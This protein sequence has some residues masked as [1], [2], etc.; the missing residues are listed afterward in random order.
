MT[1]GRT[2][3]EWDGRYAGSERN[4]SATPNASAAATIATWTPGSGTRPGRGSGTPRP[5]AGLA[6]MA[7]HVR[8]RIGGGIDRG[9]GESR[10]AGAQVDGV[11]ADMR[12]W[13]PPAGA[14]STPLDHLHPADDVLAWARR[15]LAPGGAP[16]VVAASRASSQR[17][18][19]DPPT[20][21]AA[22]G[23]RR[24]RGQCG[25]AGRTAGRNWSAIYPATM[26]STSCSWRGERRFRISHERSN[27]EQRQ[28]FPVSPGCSLL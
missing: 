3:G 13:V 7:G 21:A 19:V 18:L 12:T 6:G 28:W 16:V 15:R 26:P 23:S 10:E 9:R 11:V 27:H 20:Q 14:P 25:A 22:H 5:L 2:G 8:R 17:V 1:V 4:W 24:P